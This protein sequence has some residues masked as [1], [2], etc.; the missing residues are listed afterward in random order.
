M[1]YKL[2]IKEK[3]NT[4]FGRYNKIKS[5]IIFLNYIE[6]IKNNIEVVIKFL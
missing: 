1:V 6:I 2:K 3:G 4:N 5:K